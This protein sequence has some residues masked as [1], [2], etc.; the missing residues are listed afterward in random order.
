VRGQPA[1]EITYAEWYRPDDTYSC[2]FCGEIIE[3]SGY[4]PCQV[5]VESH[6]EN[7][8]APG[9][10]WFAAHACVPQAFEPGLRRDV[11]DE[12][13]YPPREPEESGPESAKRNVGS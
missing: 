2:A 1:D 7:P 12:Y 11:E 9:Y 8:D 13:E 3:R 5:V 4:D 6:R 10:W